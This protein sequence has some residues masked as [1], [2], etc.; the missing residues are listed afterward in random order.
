MLSHPLATRLQEGTP[1]GLKWE[2]V[3]RGAQ[4][5]GNNAEWTLDLSLFFGATILCAPR[6]QRLA[7]PG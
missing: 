3:R 5:V 7:F 1:L 4:S 6:P 2:T